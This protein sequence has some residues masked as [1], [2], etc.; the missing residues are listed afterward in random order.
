[1]KPVNGSSGT[2]STPIFPIPNDLHR[3]IMFLSGIISLKQNTSTTDC[4]SVAADMLAI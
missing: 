2:G 3:R 1:L 4:Y